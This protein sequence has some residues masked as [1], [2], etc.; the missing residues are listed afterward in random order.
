[1]SSPA[2]THAP[3]SAPPL[4]LTAVVAAC[5][6]ALAPSTAHAAIGTPVPLGAG[7]TFA[8]L[9]GAGVTNTGATTLGGDA[10]SFPTT[11][12][13]GAGTITYVGGV[14]R[15]GDAVTQQA[16][17]DLVTAYNA[18]SAQTP[19]PLAA[20]ELGGLTLEPGVYDTGG[21]IELNGNLTLDANGDPNAVFVFQSLST[22]LAAAG[23]SITF[24]D[25]ATACNLYWRVPS[26]ATIEAGSQFAGTILAET[27]I[28]FEAGAT[29]QGRALA[30]TGE[31]TLISNT[32]TLPVCSPTTP[33]PPVTG[34][35][36]AGPGALAVP[37]APTPRAAPQV[38][39]RPRGGVATGDGSSV[40][41]TGTDT[42][43]LLAV[44]AGLAGIGAVAALVAWSPR[45]RRR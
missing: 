25:G 5:A 14:E 24:I 22:L 11:S 17:T 18:A 16:K 38:A 19:D 3:A 10:G 43:V 31:V 1:M 26:S 12:I 9:A 32:I 27:T 34:P 36:A 39:V 15:G 29:L 37:A 6:L 7:A 45:L 44:T 13:T 40:V 8:V 23:S 4:S 41:R 33:V 30:Q 35:E 2:L 20:V 28:S 42:P 21:E